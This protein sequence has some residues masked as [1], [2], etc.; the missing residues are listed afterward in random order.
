MT[1][2]HSLKPLT[3]S[4]TASASLNLHLHHPD[5]PN[6]LISSYQRA[7][8]SGTEVLIVSAYL[9]QWKPEA[10]LNPDCRRFRMVVGTD[11]GL[12]RKAACRAVLAWLP[13]R[14]LVGFRVADWTSGYH[15]KAVF[16]REASGQAFAVIGSSNLTA[17]AFGSNYEA[18]V[19]VELTI[20][21]WVAARDWVNNIY[22]QSIGVSED[23]LEGYHE[24]LPAHPSKKGSGR[25]SYKAP[26]LPRP[27]GTANAIRIRRKIV[28]AHQ[29]KRAALLKAVRQCATG[30]LSPS[31][32]YE[33]LAAHWSAESGNRIQ[34][35]GFEIKGK[36][37]DWR[38]FAQS[39]TAILAAPEAERDD[40]VIDEIDRLALERVP[41]RR[42]FLSEMLCLEFPSL[43]PILN[44]PVDSFFS[45][46]KLKSAR[47]LSEGGRYIDIAQK[48][49]LALAM[50]KAHP[51]KN[52]AELDAVIWR[53]Y[54]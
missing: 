29:G 5:K 25:A 2:K 17:A 14:Q 27:V 6:G 32:F 47:G 40:I 51:A 30:K 43:Y 4:E 41:T 38:E 9:T 16:W 8:M 46:M 50:D 35:S 12:T 39:L 21:Q 45:N 53:A 36:H 11:F 49:R 52:L 7:L 1:Q 31:A 44:Q 28:A 22:A 24:A 23:W 34:G 3:S 18:N 13:R 37:S 54:G 42:A 33:S 48:L 15:P 20:D 19:V 26:A 10:Q